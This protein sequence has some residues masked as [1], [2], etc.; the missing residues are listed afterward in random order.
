MEPK[1]VV[2][3]VPPALAPA[4]A[5]APAAPGETVTP[6]KPDVMRNFFIA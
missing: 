2:P 1:V 6:L 4:E 3:P 5:A